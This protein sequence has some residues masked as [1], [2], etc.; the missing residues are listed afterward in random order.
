MDLE[1]EENSNSN[2]EE[3]ETTINLEDI[4]PTS[5]EEPRGLALIINVENF[6]DGSQRV[7]S[8]DDVGK[9]RNLW[10][11][12]HYDVTTCTEP[13]FEVSSL[14]TTQKIHLKIT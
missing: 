14:L 7:G 8:S 11:K 10:R 6:E 1:K 4:Y 2:D 12:L 13:S 5:T 9:H 3:E